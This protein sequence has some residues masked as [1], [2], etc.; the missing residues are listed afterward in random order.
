MWRDT[1][2]TNQRERER[3][4]EITELRPAAHNKG[5][6][7]SYDRPPTSRRFHL[8]SHDPKRNTDVCVVTNK[9]G[10]ITSHLRFSSIPLSENGTVFFFTGDDIGP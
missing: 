5:G 2:K 10:E 1:E 6:R 4:R 3:E 9:K 8:S 7:G